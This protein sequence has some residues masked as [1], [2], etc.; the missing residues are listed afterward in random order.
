MLGPF[1]YFQF[2]GESVMGS[3]NRVDSGFRDSIQLYGN[4]SL[5]VDLK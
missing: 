1:S 3:V 5:Q 4:V 2:E